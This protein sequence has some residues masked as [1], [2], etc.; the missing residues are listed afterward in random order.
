[1]LPK[2]LIITLIILPIRIHIRQQSRRSIT[3]QDGSNRRGRI[4]TLDFSSSITVLLIRAITIV[5]PE[6]VD[7]PRIAGTGGSTS[8]VPELGLFENQ[9][10]C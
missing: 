1:M 3:L 8:G 4:R 6:T 7:G 5:G 10:S 2:A 9:L